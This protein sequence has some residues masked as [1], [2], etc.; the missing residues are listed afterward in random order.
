MNETSGNWECHPMAPPPPVGSPQVRLE[1][2]GASTPFL[3]RGGDD[4]DSSG[5]EARTSDSLGESN[6]DERTADAAGASAGAGGSNAGGGGLAGTQRGRGNARRAKVDAAAPVLSPPPLSHRGGKLHGGSTA[7][8]GTLAADG[9]EAGPVVTVGGGSTRVGSSRGRSGRPALFPELRDRSP[10]PAGRRYTTCAGSLSRSPSPAPRPSGPQR[11]ARDTLS[12]T[13]TQGAGALMSPAGGPSIVAPQLPL[14]PPSPPGPLRRRASSPLLSGQ[15]GPAHNMPLNLP[16]AAANDGS[17]AGMSLLDGRVMVPRGDSTAA[18]TLAG[19]MATV[20]AIQAALAGG[21]SFQKAVL[22]RGPTASFEKRLRTDS[23][24]RPLSA[25]NTNSP[26]SPS[27]P[28]PAGPASAAAGATTGGLGGRT[29]SP[30]GTPAQFDA[31]QRVITPPGTTPQGMPP[32]VR[33]SSSGGGTGSSRAFSGGSGLCGVPEVALGPPASSGSVLAG[34]RAATATPAGGS[35]KGSSA[36]TSATGLG[37]RPKSDRRSEISDVQ[38]F[39]P[40]KDY[41]PTSMLFKVCAYCHVLV[42]GMALRSDCV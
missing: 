7:L 5:E 25:T 1:P 38:K 18:A 9:E 12:L 24:D 10:S 11:N 32:L 4:A 19:G 31:L 41:P 26:C 36:G 34:V 20:D 13:V 30:L 8:L 42:L 37:V 28:S 27:H 21:S 39:Q 29:P 2:R 33:E 17:V 15:A 14:A 16:V 3:S 35:S 22:G 40:R 6:G 23:D